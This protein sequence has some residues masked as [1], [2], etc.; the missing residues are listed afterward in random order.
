MT[1]EELEQA[2]RDLGLGDEVVRKALAD[3]SR[4]AASSRGPAYDTIT[5]AHT[6]DAP[7]EPADAKLE[8]GS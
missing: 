7:K 5:A 6:S 1:R 3:L 2:F 8:S 4:S